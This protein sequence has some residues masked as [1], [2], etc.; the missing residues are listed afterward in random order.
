MARYSWDLDGAS[1]NLLI[2][3]V[4][5]VLFPQCQAKADHEWKTG[6]AEI[7]DALNPLLLTQSTQSSAE[8]CSVP[9]GAKAEKSWV[10]MEIPWPL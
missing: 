4:K 5:V 8:P 9:Q 1:V 2:F 3:P 10:G 7:P 6:M